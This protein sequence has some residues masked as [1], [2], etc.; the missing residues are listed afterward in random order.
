LEYV[1]SELNLFRRESST[2]KEISNLT[3][4]IISEDYKM[5]QKLLFKTAINGTLILC[6]MNTVDRIPTIDNINQDEPIPVSLIIKIVNS[7]QTRDDR[8]Q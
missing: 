1:N 7:I 5:L 6:N 8:I 3:T 2:V 4:E